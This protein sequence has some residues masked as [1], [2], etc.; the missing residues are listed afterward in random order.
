MQ[1]CFCFLE[2]KLNAL[3]RLGK[4]GLL[5]KKKGAIGLGMGEMVMKGENN[6]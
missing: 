1:K 2:T 5:E 4:D 3:V 6:I